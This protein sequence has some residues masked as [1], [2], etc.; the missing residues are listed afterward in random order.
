MRLDIVGLQVAHINVGLA[1]AQ[2]D[3]PEVVAQRQD[4]VG[5][6]RRGGQKTRRAD[7][8][9][10]VAL[11]RKLGGNLLRALEAEIEID[12]GQDDHVVAISGRRG[13]RDGRRGFGQR[14]FGR[15]P[16]ACAGSPGIQ[17]RRKVSGM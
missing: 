4:L 7:P 3:L 2:M 15:M 17:E 5:L 1:A 14:R 10:A 9:D 16:A 6:G 8:E 12:D 11:A 13:F